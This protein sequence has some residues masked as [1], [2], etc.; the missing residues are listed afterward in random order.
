VPSIDII[1]CEAGKSKVYLVNF[2]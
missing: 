1:R 2:V